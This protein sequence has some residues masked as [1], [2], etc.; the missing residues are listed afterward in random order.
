METIITN[1]TNEQLALLVAQKT[2]PIHSNSVPDVLTAATKYLKWL[3]DN[4]P[5]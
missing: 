1:I 4:K 5:K 3:N 2:H